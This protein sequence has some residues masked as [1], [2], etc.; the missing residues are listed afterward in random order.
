MVV[1]AVVVGADLL[2]E[3]SGFVSTAVMGMAMANQEQLDVSRILEFHGT[4]VSLLIGMLFVL[5]SAS[6]EPSK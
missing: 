2:R 1:A 4:L 3:D 5:I 6:V